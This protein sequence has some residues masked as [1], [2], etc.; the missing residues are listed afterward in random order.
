VADLERALVQA[1]AERKVRTA[2]DLIESAQR[3]LGRACAELSPVIGGI[4]PWG[5][6]GK[7]YDRVHAEW[8]RTKALL[9]GRKLD[10]DETGRGA[11]AKGLA[12]GEGRPQ[13]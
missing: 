6:V 7:L 13:P 2:L 10:L 8:H 12:A 5:R 3:Q 9:D 1:E 4:G 11:L